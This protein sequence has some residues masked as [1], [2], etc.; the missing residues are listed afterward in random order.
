MLRV[1]LQEVSEEEGE[2]E[3]V[4]RPK[5]QKKGKEKDKDKDKGKKKKR[6]SAFVDDA[7]EEVRCRPAIWVGL[8][9]PLHSCALRP[10]LQYMHVVHQ[11]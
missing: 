11:V 2:E 7:A 1:S 3:F 4:A 5:Q 8:L 9:C 6:A 10:L